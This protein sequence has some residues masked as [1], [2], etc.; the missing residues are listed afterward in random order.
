MDK[1]K[2]FI[3]PMSKNIVDTIIEYSQETKN[4]I[5]FVPSRRQVDYNGG[6][7]NNWNTN[8][9]SKYV[10]NKILLK[11]DHA[12]P[13]QG[14][15]SDS[16]FRSLEEDC[17][18]FDLIHIDPWKKYPEYSKG[19]DWTID[20]INFCFKSNPKLQFEIGTEEAIRR[21]EPEELD[22]FVKDLQNKLDYN[23]FNQIKYIVVQSGT[24]LE[25]NTNTGTYN[26]DRLVSMLE[27]AKKHNL[28]SKEHNG[29]YIPSSLIKE[30]MELGLD[31]INIAPEFGLIETNTY[32]DNEIDIEKFW[33][34]CYESNRWVKWVSK[35][36]NPVINKI[37]LIKI[38]GH[39]VLSDPKFLDI[40]PD[41]DSLIKLN[42]KNKLNEFFG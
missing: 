31:S 1:V 34:I 13:G 26:K 7:V 22:K 32:L 36:F 25:G 35:D 41:L 19:L 37:E 38:C 24:S 20:M 21:F 9:F 18:F 40:K 6:Y 11:R 16:G 30:K 2:Y 23:T 10:D 14:Y 15:T 5:G 28:L 12:G 3:G 42:I 27:V 8:E 33:K 4:L 39:Y 17:K 29:D